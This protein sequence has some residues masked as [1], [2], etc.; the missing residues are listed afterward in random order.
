[1]RKVENLNAD[2]NFT[3]SYIIQKDNSKSTINSQ[4]SIA[5]KNLKIPSHMMNRNKINMMNNDQYNYFGYSN[6]VIIMVIK[7]IKIKTKTNEIMNKGERNQLGELNLNM[8]NDQYKNSRAFYVNKR[9]TPN[10]S[11][12][13]NLNVITFHTKVLNKS[14]NKSQ[15]I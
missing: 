4:T 5:T 15:F 3:L 1:M 12:N 10:Q 13:E 9:H 11:N 14:L 8:L 2:E 6:P 7:E